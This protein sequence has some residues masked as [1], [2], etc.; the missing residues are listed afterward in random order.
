MKKVSVNVSEYFRLPNPGLKGTFDRIK[1]GTEEE[2]RTPL[3]PNRSV[4]QVLSDWME[5]LEDLKSEWPGLYDFELDLSRKVG[6]LSVM[7]P[8]DQRMADIESYWHDISLHAVPLDSRAEEAVR[9]E[10]IHC[11]GMNLRSQKR[12]VENMKLSTNSGSPFYTKRR[13]VVGDTIPCNT[14]AAIDDV[15]TII[16]KL[17]SGTYKACAVL[18]WRGQEGGPQIDDIKQ[19]TVWMMPFALNVQELQ[20]YQPFIELCQRY[21]YVPAWISN[22]SVDNHIT[23]LFDTKGSRDPIICTDFTKFDQHFNPTL[24][25]CAHNL[26]KGWLVDNDSTQDWLREVFP[27]K[28]HIPLMIQYGEIITGH[29][30]MGS[31]SG[32]TN[33]D[34]TIVHRTL[35]HESAILSGV[36]LNPHSMCLGDD[37]ILSYPNIDVDTVV[38]HYSS[39][40]L[41][42]N[43]DKQSVSTDECV[44]LRRWHNKN[45]RVNG[46][47]VGVYSTCRA[48]G[49]LLEQERFIG[50]AILRS[51]KEIEYQKIL[52]LRSL[53]ILEQVKFHPLRESFVDFV[54]KGDR[55]RL[56]L[57]IPGF[58]DSKNL[59]SLSEVATSS[60]TD[61][62]GYNLQQMSKGEYAKGINDWWIVKYLR[63]KQ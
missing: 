54:L 60:N 48:L 23:K 38:E 5:H 26:L 1:Q 37:G 2:Y 12:T 63:S 42:M 36:H 9:R 6:P 31:G 32:G 8:L 19:R 62:I 40:G 28:Y 3:F 24:Q 41:E 18:G 10:W 45:Y 50:K 55:Y 51:G 46:I 57:S 16:Q 47:C 43:P 29:H 22:E 53:S 52:I 44:Y 15:D 30:G 20:L 49:K 25:A 21:E 35:Q 13:S 34:E 14:Y 59:N 11:S 7:K 17:P 58:F 56:G 39:H 4:Q 33:A 61:V 27:I